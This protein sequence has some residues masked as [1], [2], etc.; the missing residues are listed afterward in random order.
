M[1][2]ERT[3]RKGRSIDGIPS[4]RAAI[5]QHTKAGYCWGQ[6]LFPSPE[7]PFPT[8]WGWVRDQDNAWVPFWTALLQASES[9]Q[10]LLKL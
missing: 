1:M 5:Q 8:N 6:A 4:T 10:E 9:C 2:P 7:L 3:T